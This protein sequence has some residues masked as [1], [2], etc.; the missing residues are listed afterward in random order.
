MSGL[1][2]QE[3]SISHMKLLLTA[4]CCSGQ[5]Q[6]S[7]SSIHQENRSFHYVVLGHMRLFFCSCCWLS[8]RFLPLKTFTVC[9]KCS[10]GFSLWPLS[11]L[12]LLQ[13]ETVS[14][15]ST[16]LL[17][18][19]LLCDDWVPF[20]W[21][22]HQDWQCGLLNE[23]TCRWVGN[24]LNGP[25]TCKWRERQ[26]IWLIVWTTVRIQNLLKFSSYIFF[27]LSVKPIRCI[28]KCISI[29]SS[30]PLHYPEF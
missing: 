26:L 17:L 25:L 1:L 9:Q 20:W 10:V 13:C 19:C 23:G 14:H 18:K 4:A 22:H 3:A 12:D 24:L 11:Q 27:F 16:R 6:C 21:H 28:W 15:W 29:L 5:T 2:W 30:D 7:S 8:S